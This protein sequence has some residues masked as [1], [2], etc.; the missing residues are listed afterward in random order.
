MSLLAEAT[1]NAD[2]YSKPRD[3]IIN[4]GNTCFHVNRAVV[5]AKSS[6]L[7]TL[8]GEEAP[9]TMITIP[10]VDADSFEAILYY[11]YTG[12]YE[13][14][15][16]GAGDIGKYLT[17]STMGQ[18]AE[19]AVRRFADTPFAVATTPLEDLYKHAYIFALGDHYQIN[20]LKLKATEKF[21]AARKQ[22]HSISPTDFLEIASTIL[23]SHGLDLQL[24]RTEL[25]AMMTDNLHLAQDEDFV[26]AVSTHP[27]FQ[28]FI[29]PLI[30]ALAAR[31][32]L[33][34]ANS[35]A[36]TLDSPRDDAQLD[37]LIS[38]HEEQV[39]ALRSSHK[40][41]TEALTRSHEAQ[42]IHLA[43]AH[44]DAM[45]E[46]R[47]SHHHTRQATIKEYEYDISDM[48]KKHTTDMQILRAS[49]PTRKKVGE[50]MNRLARQIEACRHCGKRPFVYR[51]EWQSI[52]FL[53]RCTQCGTK[54][55]L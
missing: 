52:G 34:A 44:D 29:A 23:T 48:A 22:H 38:S 20:S 13:L 4:C 1:T 30:S 43:R 54:H 31:S 32:A 26:K 3:L 21:Q 8:C 16:E 35:N 39:A 25:I 15:G 27:V 51:I 41:A 36:Q 37:A 24:L 45:E 28:P 42:L 10:P 40:A 17:L 9:H 49:F 55:G 53:A 50:D 47:L 19:D 33:P 7:G 18:A 11:I 12:D 5:C 2:I 46:T 6:V 14:E